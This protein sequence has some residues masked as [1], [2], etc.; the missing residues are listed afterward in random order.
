MQRGM[1]IKRYQRSIVECQCLKR[2]TFVERVFCAG[3][4][5]N[6]IFRVK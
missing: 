6:W 1:R 2:L 5:L 4:F 3:A